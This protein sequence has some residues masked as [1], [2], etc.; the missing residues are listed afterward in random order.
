MGYYESAYGGF[1]PYVPVAE[2]RRR[3]ARE[4]AS[5]HKKGRRTAPV[6]LSGRTIATTFW[7]RAWCDNLESYSDY[8]N[9]LPRGRTYVRNGSVLDLQIEPGK[10]SALVMGSQLYRIQITISPIARAP[11]QALIKQCAGRIDSLVELLR[12][13]LSQGVME[14]ITRKGSGLFPGPRELRLECSCPDVAS[15]CKHVAA[16]LYGVGARLDAEPELLF[17]LR[18]LDQLEL[19]T[20]AS[21]AHTLSRGAASPR[22]SALADAELSELFGIELDPGATPSPAPPPASPPPAK[23]AAV[24]SVQRA[25]SRPPAPRPRTKIRAQMSRQELLKSGVAASLI[26]LWLRTGLLV[27]S[28]TRGVYDTTASVRRQLTHLLSG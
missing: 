28:G 3:A 5:L 19:I 26:A 14:L 24:R 8:E 9:R 21:T 20:G 2:R 11:W 7:G 18:Q 25:T 15:L 6:V 22:R 4:L 27:P 13:R 1:A 16:T 12:G 10:I 23:A 17:S